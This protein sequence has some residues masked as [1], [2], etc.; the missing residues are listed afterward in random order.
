MKLQFIVAVGWVLASPGALA[1]GQTPV[2]QENFE[3]GKL[4]RERWEQRVSGTATIAV[5]TVEGA[6]G[7]YALHVHYPEM[8]V[9]SYAFAVA[10]HLPDSVKTHFFGRAY[11]KI[12]ASLTATH[13]PL[14]FAGEPGGRCRNSMRSGRRGRTG[15]RRSRRTNRRRDKGGEK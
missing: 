1:Y 15:C 7:K 3:G 14:I 8:A 5:E 10:T 4:D 13:N 9:R 12:S 11:M 6:H 2:F